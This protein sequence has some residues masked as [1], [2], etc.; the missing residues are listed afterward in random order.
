MAESISFAEN[1]EALE[2]RLEQA[3]DELAALEDRWKAYDVETKQVRAVLADLKKTMR[4]ELPDAAQPSSGVAGV[5]HVD[6][7]PDTGRPPRGARR[8]QIEAICE[9]LGKEQDSFRT[10]DVLNTLRD[11]E[12]EMSDGLKSYTYAV[13]TQ[14]QNEGMVEKIGRGTWTWQG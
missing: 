2:R 7:N 12:D 13:M 14:L 9:K 3:R 10:V 4:G 8:A 1:I 11:V 5:P 6:I